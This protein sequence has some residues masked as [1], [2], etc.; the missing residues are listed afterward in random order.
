TT[1]LRQLEDCLG[2][3]Q[4]RGVRIVANAGGLNPS[5]CADAVCALAERLGLAVRVAQVS[6]DDLAGRL[7]EVGL[8]P[9]APPVSANAYLGGWGITAA[10]AGGAD[11]VVTGRVTD[12]ALVTGPAAWHHGWERD[13]WDALAGAVV[14]G[15]VLECGAQATGGNY[16]F[17]TEVPGLIHVGF[18]VAEIAADGSAVITKHPGTG[19][20]VSV[21]TVTAQLLYEIGDPAYLGPDVVADF[22]TVLLTHEGSD[23]VRISGVRGSPPPPRAKVSVNY[24]G[25]F[26]NSVTFL[27]CGLD[28]EAKAALLRDQLAPALTGL[29]EL[30]MALVRLD[31]EDSPTEEQASALLR[32]SAKDPDPAKVGRAFSA[33][34][35]ELA[36]ASIPGFHVTAPPGDA[37]PFGVFWPGYVDSALVPAVVVHADG[38]RE[39][40]AAT[41]G[42]EPRPTPGSAPADAREPPEPVR[43]V[44]LGT[45]AGARSGD[46]GGTANL[47]VWVRS[48]AGYRWL[49]SYLQPHRLAELLPEAAGLAITRYELPNLRALNFVL[50]GLLGDG[51]ASSTRFDP[52]AKA[53]GEW[54][55]ARWV[56]VPEEVLAEEAAAPR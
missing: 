7:A 34:A 42:V 5:G 56:E 14:A 12:A 48:A 39:E 35:I 22:R 25:G 43:R 53:L 50:P 11:I 1:F 28:I 49:V 38:R 4:E 8:R 23:R 47:G 33:P 15:H 21:G 16:A 31:R 19:G 13:A 30:D 51:V 24:L 45:V 9:P 6:G 2:L 54:L 55:R 37:S 36:L 32:V 20:Q 17:F 40:V 18:P 44:P 29:A 52:Q 41:P 3:A 26:R 10:L 46:K 27:L